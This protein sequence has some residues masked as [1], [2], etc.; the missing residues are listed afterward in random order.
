MNLNSYLGLMGKCVRVVPGKN[1]VALSETPPQSN[2]RLI[3]DTPYVITLDADSLL[4]PQYASTL[5]RLM[6][7]PKHVRT[8]VAQTPYSAFPNPP[9]VLERAARATTDIQYFV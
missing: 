6:E 4:K 5:V 2:S 1:G 8:A 7:Q 3:P 9:G